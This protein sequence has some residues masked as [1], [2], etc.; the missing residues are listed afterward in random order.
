MPRFVRTICRTLF[1]QVWL[2]LFVLAVASFSAVAQAPAGTFTVS[3]GGVSI[4]PTGGGAIP[5][6]LTSVN[7]FA[8][9]IVVGCQPPSVS[10]G[11]KI[12]VCGGGPVRLYSLTA[13]Q[14]VT[15]TITL[16]AYGSPLPAG[17]GP[18]NHPVIG[19]L[20][21]VALLSGLTLR[22]RS[23]RWLTLPLIFA[24]AIPFCS[25]LGCGGSPQGF[26][27]GAYNYT[28]TATQYG[29]ATPL[30]QGTTATVTVR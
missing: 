3:A 11:V 2:L 14:V 13:D 5:F 24:A 20:L 15:G 17:F 22:R 6:T 9:S 21:V 26:T 27:P 18:A 12:P 16:F 10:A 7:G 23:A 29:S 28:V 8:G 19:L 4:A 25:I 1:Y 30:Q